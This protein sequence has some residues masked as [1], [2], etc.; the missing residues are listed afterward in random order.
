MLS[1]LPE[2]FPL[3]WTVPGNGTLST[4]GNNVRAVN[5][6]NR[7]PFQVPVDAA[8]NAV[9][10]AD[11]NTPE[12]FVT[13][14]FYFCSFAHDYFMTLGFTEKNG[15]FQAVNRP[16]HG[17][18][19]DAVLALAHPGAVEG[20]ANMATRADG[21]TAVMNMGLVTQTG[22]HTANAFDVVLHEYVHGVTNRL[23]GGMFD[24]NGLMEPQSRSM[25]EGWSDYFAL[26]LINF[27]R[28]QEH[29]VVGDWV[30]DN[31]GG[32]RQRP[33]DADYPG[34]FGDIGKR[35]GQVQGTGNADLSYREVHN[36]G[37]IWC[38]ALME[39][40]RKVSAVLG[41]KER[42]YRLTWQAVVDGLKLTP[43]NPSFLVARDAI[44]RAFKAMEGGRLTSA[45]YATVQRAAWEAF[46]R[47][48]M[49]FDAFCP[50]ASF[51]GCQGGTELPPPGHTD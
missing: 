10:K 30:V 20:T 7:Q 16:G 8:G 39:L 47:Y 23:V 38:A 49:G 37:E 6:S 45:E 24:A 31:P 12:Q 41:S 9:F 22:R 28:A 27:G 29:T 13:N 18:G 33:Y 43:K 46:A 44:L 40:T 42:G 4:D 25:G 35:S 21:L 5:G 15:N 48:E 26:T 51:A 3:A 36:V 50:N 17:K 34:A 14:I 1:E 2:G 19:A 11:E 32:I